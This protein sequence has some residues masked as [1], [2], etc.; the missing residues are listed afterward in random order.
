VLSPDQFDAPIAHQR[1]S[2]EDDAFTLALQRARRALLQ[3]VEREAAVIT[4]HLGLSGAPRP[5]DL[6]A[7]Q[8][9]T[10]SVDTPGQALAGARRLIQMSEEFIRGRRLLDTP[11]IQEMLALQQRVGDPRARSLVEPF[12]LPV[13]S[14]WS[15]NRGVTYV[16]RAVEEPTLVIASHE[17]ERMRGL[18]ATPLDLQDPR[19]LTVLHTRGWL[20]YRNTRGTIARRLR[21]MEVGAL[22]EAGVDDPPADAQQRRTLIAGSPEARAALQRRP[23]YRELSE[24]A[25]RIPPGEDSLQGAQLSVAAGWA[26]S[27][28][29]QEPELMGN[30]IV[31]FVPDDL[32]LVAQHSAVRIEAQWGRLSRAFKRHLARRYPSFVAG[33]ALSTAAAAIPPA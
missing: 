30:L 12:G 9:T 4:L 6:F 17:D 31:R 21:E 29:V 8:L 16:L 10:L 26:L 11:Y 20:T 1:Y 15:T 3:I 23:A 24:L 25:Q 28:I 22:L 2:F 32:D 14:F 18:P 13:G 5:Y 19:V 33:L 27:H 7:L